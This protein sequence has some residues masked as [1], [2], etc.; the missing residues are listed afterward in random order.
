MEAYCRSL[1]KTQLTELTRQIEVVEKLGSLAHD[2]KSNPNN[3]ALIK[4]SYI[5][6]TLLRSEYRLSLSNFISPL[7]RS[8]FLG[9]LEAEKCKILASAKRPLLLSWTNE[10]KYSEFFDRNFQ[11]IFKK[12][13]DL[14]QDM[15][16][17]QA[18]KLM[19]ILWKNEGLDL[20]MLIY[21]C[22]STGY[23]TGF[24]E[25]IQ[26]SMTLFKIQ[27]KGGMRSTYQIDTLQLYKWIANHNTDSSR[28]DKAIELF[29]RSCAGFCVATFILGIGDRHPDNIMVNKQGQVFFPKSYSA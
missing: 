17:I 5:N 19:D 26:N 29:T 24:I 3:L 21:D 7:N 6:E 2:I 10:K 23:K 12:G 13:D 15:L 4:S 18:L 9:L 14:R 27:M 25:V 16:T 20:K 11:L 22:F 28:L 1:N 8:I